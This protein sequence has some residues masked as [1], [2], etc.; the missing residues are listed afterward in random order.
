MPRTLNRDA[1]LGYERDLLTFLMNE[2]P[3][4]EE[5]SSKIVGL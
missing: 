1:G 5:N 4:R 3:K 2:E